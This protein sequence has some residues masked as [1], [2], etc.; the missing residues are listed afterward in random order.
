M[1]VQGVG[2]KCKIMLS[3]QTHFYIK[4]TDK[5]LIKM[6]KDTFFILTIITNCVLVLFSSISK[7]KLSF[8]FSIKLKFSNIVFIVKTNDSSDIYSNS[9][10][11]SSTIAI[12][13]FGLYL[14]LLLLAL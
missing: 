13:L 4:Y 11:P 1:W 14:P 2:W 10:K 9:S 5:F 7:L 12:W 6:Y 3:I 8:S